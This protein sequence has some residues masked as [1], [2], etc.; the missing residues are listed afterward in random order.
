MSPEQDRHHETDDPGKKI[1]VMLASI[2]DAISEE[3]YEFAADAALG[4]S[5]I[6]PA[7]VVEYL[8]LQGKK[9]E[10]PVAQ[11]RFRDGVFALTAS[12]HE[13]DQVEASSDQERSLS[14]DDIKRINGVMED[15]QLQQMAESEVLGGGDVDAPRDVEPDYDWDQDV[16]AADLSDYTEEE[17]EKAKNTVAFKAAI[18]KAQDRGLNLQVRIKSART[19]IEDYAS[20]RDTETK[21]IT[22]R[23]L[24]SLDK[25]IARAAEEKAQ[26]RGINLQVRIKLA[27]TVI[28]DYASSPERAQAM[29]DE[30]GL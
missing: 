26:D 1:R 14:Q 24:A 5:L 15:L 13:R 7:D 20:D 11:R 9:E 30:L 10:D 6:S 4:Q 18:E 23:M 3:D 25:Y 19:V 22:A 16:F 8:H 29:L 27:R 17:I 2:T 21:T 12:L 28:E